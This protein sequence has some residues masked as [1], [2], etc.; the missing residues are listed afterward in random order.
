[1]TMGILKDVK[2]HHF[3]IAVPDIDRAIKFWTEVFGFDVRLRHE[4]PPLRAKG[5]F[6]KSEGIELELFELA[7]VKPVP[8]ERNY[9]T[10]IF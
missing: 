9:R 1:M 8:E 2:P 3:C 7:D 4:I 5:A 10:P 6:L